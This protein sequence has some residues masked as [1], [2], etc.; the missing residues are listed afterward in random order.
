MP[1]IEQLSASER[2]IDLP[3]IGRVLIR[4]VRPDDDALFEEFLD[5][6][7]AEDLRLRFFGAINP[8]DQKFI[9]KLTHPDTRCVDVVVALDE[10]TNSVLGVARL[11]RNQDDK[12]GEY[13]VLVRSSIAG[14]GLGWALMQL[15]IDSG[16]K[17]G[18]SHMEGY[19][20]AENRRMLR[21]CHELGFEIEQDANEPGIRIVRLPL[22]S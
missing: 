5:H 21:M 18:L 17:A 11:H 4:S 3:Y 15:L 10:E 16:R 9:S 22:N 13:A 2:R 14:R 20:L 19:V 8:H 1:A 12:M 7:T 6:V